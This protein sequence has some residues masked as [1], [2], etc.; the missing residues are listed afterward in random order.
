ME[1][2]EL[3]V[4]KKPLS[5]KK[6]VS[7]IGGVM[8]LPFVNMGAMQYIRGEIDE[9]KLATLIGISAIPILLLYLMAIADDKKRNYL[10]K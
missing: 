1:K 6:L 5:T 10:Y 4:K 7:I 8:A 9:Y 3:K 2:L